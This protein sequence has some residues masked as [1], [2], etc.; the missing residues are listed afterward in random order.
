LT[1][2]EFMRILLRGGRQA[3]SGGNPADS[4]TASRRRAGK[5]IFANAKRFATIGRPGGSS[6]P[7][8]GI[9]KSGF[10]VRDRRIRK[11]K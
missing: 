10:A 9:S 4:F 8:E 11:D 2:A 7:R 5:F 1:V 6:L 3:F